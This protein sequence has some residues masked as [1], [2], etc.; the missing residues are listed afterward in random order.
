MGGIQH[1][2]APNLCLSV[3]TYKE[4]SIRIFTCVRIGE[5]VCE[6]DAATPAYKVLSILVLEDR[7]SSAASWIFHTKLRAADVQTKP[8]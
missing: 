8:V 4:G 6:A 2:T 1:W 5:W 3:L 7:V